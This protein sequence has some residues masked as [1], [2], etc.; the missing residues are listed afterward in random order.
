MYLFRWERQNTSPNKGVSENYKAIEWNPLRVKFLNN[1]YHEAP[2][3][4]QCNMSNGD[5][6]P[7]YWENTPVTTVK[8][9][10]PPPVRDCKNTANN[11]E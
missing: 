11:V 8:T 6:F 9:P 5:R 3:S 10:L 1:L 7:G 4:M 2:L